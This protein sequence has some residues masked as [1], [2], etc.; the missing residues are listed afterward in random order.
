MDT[1]L[2]PKNRKYI[3]KMEPSNKYT[4][5]L[6][7]KQAQMEQMLLENRVRKLRIEE[8]HLNK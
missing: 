2:S 4:E 1:P 6:L 8:D 3:T 5:K 7:M